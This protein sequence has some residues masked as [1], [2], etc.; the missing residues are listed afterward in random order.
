MT[1]DTKT[2]V[3]ALGLSGA[4]LSWSALSPRLPAR[5][6]PLPHA[7]MGAALASATP[8]EL[9]LRPPQL[10]AGLRWGGAVSVPVVLAIAAAT[11]NPVVRSGMAQRDLPAA[12]SR[13]LL[14]RIPLGTV[15]SE[16][17][18]YRA[19]LGSAATKA[20][21]PRAGR[22][23]AALVFG[24]SHVPEAR[25]T[26]ESVPGTVAVTA[27]AGWMFS[28]LH[29]VSGSVA[30]PMLAHLAVNEAGAVAAL[31]VQRRRGDPAA[32]GS[33]VSKFRT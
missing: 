10:W 25:A 6:H 4:L 7:V 24:L 9:G 22:I 21:G 8:A 15:W 17:V 18:A 3:R 16:E 12:P 33:G 20:F 26:G 2:V 28:W 13:W 23:L 5:W 11:A 19:V 31:A 14:L 1:K 27:A 29:A 32:T 30:A